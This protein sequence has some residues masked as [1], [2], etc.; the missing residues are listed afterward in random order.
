[1]GELSLP[2]AAALGSPLTD[3]FWSLSDL[4]PVKIWGSRS[5]VV[6]LL[7]AL[8]LRA[9]LGRASGDYRGQS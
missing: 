2:R 9:F 7:G 1:M 6:E 8:L 5:M 4:R 3:P